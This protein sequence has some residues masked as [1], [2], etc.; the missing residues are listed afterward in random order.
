MV[1]FAKV[2]VEGTRG[3]EGSD[4]G[5]VSVLVPTGDKVGE[6]V[7]DVFIVDGMVSGKAAIADEGF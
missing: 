2:K 7:E 4:F 5:G 3:G 1:E 6:A